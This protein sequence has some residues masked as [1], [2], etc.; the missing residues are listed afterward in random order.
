MNK[1]INRQFTTE[2]KNAQICEKVL[3]RLRIIISKV[4]TKTKVGNYYYS[5]LKPDKAKYWQICGEMRM[6]LHCW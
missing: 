1:D 5:I 3:C 6:Q 2:V 4:Q